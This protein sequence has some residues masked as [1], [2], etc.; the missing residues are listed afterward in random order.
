MGFFSRVTN[1]WSGFLSLFVEG[2]ETKNPEIV[3]ESAINQR[4]QQYQKLMKAVSGI[5]YLRNKLQKELEEKTAKLKEVQQQL[6]VAIQQGDDEVSVVLIEQKNSLTSD[7]ERVQSELQKISQQAEDAKTSLIAFQGDIE[8]LKAEKESM[9]A[10]RENAMAQKKIQDQ[11]SNL[12][13]DADLKALSSVRES[14]N[15]LEAHVDI[16]KEI[17]AGGL[18][19]KLKEIKI[20]TSNA[21]AKNELEEIKKQMNLQ[22]NKINIEKKL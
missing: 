1:L 21:S 14:I 6:P 7:I 5:V 11:L 9:L 2:L 3:Y 15:K 17:N 18:D 13:V 19:H 16:A 20:K 4:V 8:K 22:Q 12:S 10:K